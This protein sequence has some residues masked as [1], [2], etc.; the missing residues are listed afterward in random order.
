[1]KS[2]GLLMSDPMMRAVLSGEKTA[3]R[4][5]IGWNGRQRWRWNR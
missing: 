5:F 1:M 4:W 3:T 2:H